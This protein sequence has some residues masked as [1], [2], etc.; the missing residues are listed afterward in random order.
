MFYFQMYRLTVRSSKDT[1]SQHI[2]Q[3]LSEQF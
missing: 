3:V 1:I 2:C